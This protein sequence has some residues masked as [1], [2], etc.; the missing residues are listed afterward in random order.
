M[1]AATRRIVFWLRVA[2]PILLFAII[3]SRIDLARLASALRGMQLDL[4]LYSLVIG[5]LVPVLLCAWRWQVVLRA[6]Y[7]I[8]A[9]YAFLLK[10]FWI[11]MFAGYL[12][13][14]GVG[15]DIYRVTCTARREGGL[16]VNTVAVIGEKALALLA[17][18]LLL[19]LAY[20]LVADAI[21]A[22]PILM[23]VIDALYAMG[24]VAAG[25]LALAALAGSAPGQRLRQAAE[26][27]LRRRIDQMAQG[28]RPAAPGGVAAAIRPFFAPRNLGLIVGISALNQLI[29]SYG[30][31]LMMLSVGV[32]LPLTVHV[33]IWTLMFFVF[34]A[35]ISI[36]TL[37]VREGTFIVLFG[38]FGVPPEEAL[39]GSFVGL[40]SM[41]FT[42]GLGG[43][44]WLADARGHSRDT[45]APD[46]PSP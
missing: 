2:A 14:G 39:A 28:A 11:G 25:V 44:A 30:G 13:P 18:G 36:G 38:L 20:P 40:A 17:N 41:L 6:L 21:G 5:Y 24:I 19:V 23:P 42:V 43:I 12:V 45:R 33:F 26:A 1:N 35:P 3:F 4:A 10:H 29:A 16:Q 46:S 15:T 8:R 32:D 37:G 7:G 9:S 22:P 31:R 34:L 27:R